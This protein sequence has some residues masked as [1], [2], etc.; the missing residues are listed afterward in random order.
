[1]G[2]PNISEFLVGCDGNTRPVSRSSYANPYLHE[3]LTADVAIVGAGYQGL[4]TV[5]Q[6][7]HEL[8]SEDLW[9]VALPLAAN[10]YPLSTS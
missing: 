5:F 1:M 3:P 4:R 2:T 10:T 6:K 8:D 9:A 7:R